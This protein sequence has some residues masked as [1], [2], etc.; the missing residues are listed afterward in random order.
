MES[1]FREFKILMCET[2]FFCFTARYP[3]IENRKIENKSFADAVGG[4]SRITDPLF[5]QTPDNDPNALLREI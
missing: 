2:G 4:K 5:Q 3:P 1:I